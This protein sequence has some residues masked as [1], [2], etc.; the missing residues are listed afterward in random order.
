MRRS[1]G[2][3]SGRNCCC[4]RCCCCNRS[5]DTNGSTARNAIQTICYCNRYMDVP[6]RIYHGAGYTELDCCTDT[7]NILQEIS[8]TLSEHTNSNC[9]GCCRCRSCCNC[10]S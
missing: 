6:M 4:N 9:N 5:N 10:C 7:R 1:R 3:F 8:D 2:L